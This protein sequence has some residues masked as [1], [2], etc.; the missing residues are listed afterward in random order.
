MF[1]RIRE[2]IHGLNYTTY[3]HMNKHITFIV[4]YIQNQ[5]SGISRILSEWQRERG[6]WTASFRN[7][8]ESLLVP[9]SRTVPSVFNT[10]SGWVTYASVSRK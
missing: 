9:P 1:E 8:T 7:I 6:W 5:D 2:M 10:T 4:I 3:I